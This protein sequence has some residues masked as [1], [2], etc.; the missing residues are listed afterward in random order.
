M[1]GCA[2][3]VLMDSVVIVM[4]NKFCAI[5]H[6]IIGIDEGGAM[7]FLCKIGVHK[8]YQFT[9]EYIS[10][11]IFYRMKFCEKCGLEKEDL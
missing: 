8:W 1:P 10:D 7:N 6:N 2:L 5:S 11:G 4:G 9:K 3:P